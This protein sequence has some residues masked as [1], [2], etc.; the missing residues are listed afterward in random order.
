MLLDNDLHFD[1]RFVMKQDIDMCLQVLMKY[2]KV[3]MERRYSF[4]CRPAMST[5]GGV[6]SYR[7]QD[8][9]NK[10]INLLRAKWGGQMF[11]KTASKR[12]N[13]YTLN[14]QNPFRGE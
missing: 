7:N 1:E 6:G 10:M 13:I 3:F 5:V 4:V 8:L 11:G 2:R 9:E 14:I 12:V